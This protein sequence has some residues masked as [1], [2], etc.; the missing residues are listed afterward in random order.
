MMRARVSAKPSGLAE[1]TIKLIIGAQ[2]KSVPVDPECEYFTR[3]W[4]YYSEYV[5][6]TIKN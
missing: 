5:R 3:F 1:N 4:P 6:H 2:D